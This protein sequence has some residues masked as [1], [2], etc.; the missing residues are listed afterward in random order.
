MDKSTKTT[1]RN[2]RR[3]SFFLYL[4][5]VQSCNHEATE[6]KRIEKNLGL[7]LFFKVC[8]NSA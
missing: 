3:Y 5:T 8:Y 4:V 7:T 6:V 1:N 2:T